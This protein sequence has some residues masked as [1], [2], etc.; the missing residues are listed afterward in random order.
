LTLA[1]LFY[2]SALINS[3]L[4]YNNDYCWVWQ[5]IIQIIINSL[6]GLI[7]I[8]YGLMNSS[9]HTFVSCVFYYW[10]RKFG[11]RHSH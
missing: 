5:I 10:N 6:S 8:A 11:K 3:H 7:T 9:S 2:Y 1:E 4:Y